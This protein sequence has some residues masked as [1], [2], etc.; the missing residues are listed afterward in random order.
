MVWKI[1]R[2]IRS[3]LGIADNAFAFV[4][5]A[6]CPQPLSGDPWNNAAITSCQ[7]CFPVG[8]FIEAIDARV[9]FLAK[10]G[11]VGRDIQIAREIELA[12]LVS[13]NDDSHR[14]VVRYGNG[15]RGARG[16]EHWTSWLPREATRIREFLGQSILG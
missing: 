4:N 8:H 7:H 12:D 3:E 16:R 13:P 1:F 11:P 10:C 6:R 9:I 2:A 5:L 15:S 14:L